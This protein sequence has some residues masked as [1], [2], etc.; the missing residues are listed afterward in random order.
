[1]KTRSQ[2]QKAALQHHDIDALFLT[3]HYAERM[4]SAHQR[5]TETEKQ[6]LYAW[7]ARH[8]GIDGQAC[9][10]DWPGWAAVYARLEH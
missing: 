2:A 4:I 3:A 1:M 9:S 10:M 6:D 5:M 7:E 8:L